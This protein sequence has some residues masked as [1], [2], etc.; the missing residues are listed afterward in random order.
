MYD[1]PDNDNGLVAQFPV[2]GN[3]SGINFDGTI[4]VGDVNLNA[5][6]TLGGGR[7]TVGVTFPIGGATVDVVVP[8]GKS[9]GFKISGDLNHGIH[10]F[11]QMVGP[12]RYRLG[13]GGTFR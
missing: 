9:P 7:P 10:G 3:G 11:I 6:W 4:D 13:F 2:N 8:P 5:N 1:N 12:G